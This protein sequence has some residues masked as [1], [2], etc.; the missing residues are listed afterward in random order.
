[1]RAVFFVLLALAALT[2]F[3]VELRPTWTAL[4]RAH[5]LIHPLLGVLAA[6]A[7]IGY[8]RAH[9]RDKG[10]S[11][12]KIGAL[13][14]ALL[15]LAWVACVLSG[16]APLSLSR[17]NRRFVELHG[18][19]GWAMLP[20]FGLHVLRTTWLALR[21][22]ARWTRFRE[23]LT[24]ARPTWIGVSVV[25]VWTAV[26]AL[27]RP[28]WLRFSIHFDELLHGAA[29]IAAAATS[30]SV[31]RRALAM[32]STCGVGSVCHADLTREFER[33]AHR[34]SPETVH[35]QKI[36]ALLA[37]ERGAPA[38][39]FCG[40]CHAPSSVV[41]EEPAAATS[42][43]T[44]V[45]HGL[46]CL[47]C[48]SMGAASLAEHPGRRYAGDVPEGF[49]IDLQLDHLGLFPA[50]GDA[51]ARDFERSTSARL[52]QLDPA[53]HARVMR[54]TL[55]DQDASCLA[56]HQEHIPRREAT[57]FTAVRCIDCHMTMQQPFSESG[58]RKPHYLVGANVVLPRLVHDEEMERK[59]TDWVTGRFETR[60]LDAFW[61]LRRPTQKNQSKAV[62]LFM[63]IEPLGPARAGAELR[64]RIAT[65]N[66]GIG[67]PFPSG[68][69]DLYDV[70][71]EVRVVD[72]Q[73]ALV[74]ASGQP[75][76]VAPRDDGVIRLGGWVSDGEGRP[77]DRHRVWEQAER[78]VRA[79]DPNRTTSHELAL[80]IPSS[81]VG[82][83]TVEARWNYDRLNAPF[84]SWAYAGQ[85][86]ELPRIVI[87]SVEQK[88]A[89]VAADRP[90]A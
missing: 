78:H 22:R 17:A 50:A 64:L 49:R 82:P 76:G 53:A 67:H 69:I 68:V 55:I 28:S 16:L 75:G 57:G 19:I 58:Q 4:F 23:R 42:A 84:V 27:D 36:V 9:V 46:G 72:A 71:L 31:E 33:S 70:W 66:V 61:E 26:L 30:P 54:P 47:V 86:I 20:V 7:S 81:A 38:S 21:D 8:L 11:T 51:A 29:P 65:S 37:A 32:S 85:A 80:P 48:H 74:Y 59:V 90:P 79:I 39:R 41:G 6:L 34:R 56:C 15:A 24:I 63:A 18:W 2:G 60:A 73:G 40:S 13:L 10:W 14:G 62:W 88:I 3:Y 35:F 44:V 83:L 12:A 25:L 43:G 89:L 52:I 1:M 77:I 5:L 45:E 87:A